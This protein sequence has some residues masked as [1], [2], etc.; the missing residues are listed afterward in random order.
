[1]EGINMGVKRSYRLFYR[2]GS[3]LAPKDPRNITESE[4][5]VANRWLDRRAH[6]LM[7]KWR[8]KKRRGVGV[9]TGSVLLRLWYAQD[10]RA[11]MHPKWKGRILLPGEFKLLRW[12]KGFIMKQKRTGGKILLYNSL[13]FFEDMLPPLIRNHYL[14]DINKRA[15]RHAGIVR[16]IPKSLLEMSDDEF[17]AHKKKIDDEYHVTYGVGRVQKSN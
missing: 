2:Q 15:D 8:L 12:H 14:S 7:R 10:T 9:Y 17:A 5:L 6:L 11:F 1:M 16:E 3:K 4:F 13:D